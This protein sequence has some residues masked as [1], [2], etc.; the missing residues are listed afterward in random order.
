M[1]RP[2]RS[3]FIA[4]MGRPNVGKSTFLNTVIGSKISITTSKPQTTRDRI[5]GIFD[6]SDAQI[7]FLDTP[8]IHQAGKALNKYMVEKALS[9][10]SDADIAMVMTAP[11]ETVELLSEVTAYVRTSGKE[12][13]LVLN[14]ADLLSQ[15]DREKR[16]GA[17]AGAGDFRSRYAVSSLTG[18]GIGELMNGLKNLLPEGPR[19]FPE[20]MITDAP[21][22]F[23]CQELI[24][25]KVF[26]LTQK[27]IPYA[28]AVEVEEFREGEPTYI[29][30]AVHVERPSQKGIVIGAGG[31]M[32]KEI[33]KQARM[34]IQRLLGTR[35]FLELFV[36]VTKDWT[37]KPS[38]LK[39]LGYK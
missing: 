36:K 16:L 22:R 8:G 19:F 13:V 1:D 34:D 28:A 9:T 6:T 25:E 3:G 37:R 12:A 10:L 20:D 33:G 21:L 4:I 32:L 26:T 18:E 27:E 14:K 2:I 39:D 15:E 35:V 38:R 24:R 30:A 23:L 17:L 31:K 11:D 5:L 29:R 7:I